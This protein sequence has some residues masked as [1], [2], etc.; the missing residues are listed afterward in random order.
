MVSSRVK[1]LDTGIQGICNV[2]IPG[3]VNGNARR[4]FKLSGSVPFIS[5]YALICPLL[6]KYSVCCEFLD[7]MISGICHIYLVFIQ[8]IHSDI[9][10]QL[11]SSGFFVYARPFAEKCSARIE[12]LNALIPCIRHIDSTVAA[13][14]NIFGIFEFPVFDIVREITEQIIQCLK[15]DPVSSNSFQRIFN[16]VVDALLQTVSVRDALLSP[17]LTYSLYRISLQIEFLNGVISFIGNIENIILINSNAVW[18]IQ[19]TAAF[20]AAP[21]EIKLEILSVRCKLLNAIEFR[22][23]DIKITLAIKCN[24]SGTEKFT[25]FILAASI[26]LDTAVDGQNVSVP[27]EFFYLIVAG[28]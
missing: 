7:T 24:S 8:L 19:F 6:V 4:Q 5:Q 16:Q 17:F 10:G 15:I 9:A 1:L 13:D 22:I 28:I 27:I 25:T 21:F 18:G 12:L 23:R 3:A 2:E 20:L 26:F 14:G 11:K